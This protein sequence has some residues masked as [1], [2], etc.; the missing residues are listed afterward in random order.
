[1]KQGGDIFGISLERCMISPSAVMIHRA[2][3]EEMGGFDETLPVCEDYDLWLRITARHKV[4]LIKE[5]LVVK[6]GGHSDQLS[7]KYWGMDRFRIQALEK[8]LET[9]LTICRREEVLKTL[10][11]KLKVL[12]DGCQKRGKEKE[13]KEY[14]DK[15]KGYETCFL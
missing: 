10:T 14:F 11:F 6:N 7:R 15:L 4:G 9:E 12:A 13:A 1:M 2:L 5:K 3:F 8:I